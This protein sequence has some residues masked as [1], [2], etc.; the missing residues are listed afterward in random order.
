MG[1]ENDTTGAGETGDDVED[2]GVTAVEH[3]VTVVED[4]VTAVEDGL[5]YRIGVNS[6]M[7]FSPVRSQIVDF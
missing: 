4:G 5:E 7:N 6:G 3:G 1:V 2:N